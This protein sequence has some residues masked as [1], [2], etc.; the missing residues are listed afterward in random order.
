MQKEVILKC[1]F[2]LLIQIYKWKIV[3]ICS[4]SPRGNV[5][6]NTLISR[7][8]HETL[9]R[10]PRGNVDWNHQSQFVD[11]PFHGRSPRGNVDWNHQQNTC[12]WR[13]QSRS[14]RG[15]VDWNHHFP[16]RFRWIKL[17]FPTRER[18]LKWNCVAAL[19]FKFC[20][21]PRG[22]VDWNT[23]LNSGILNTSSRSP[24]GNVD[25]NAKTTGK[26]YW[27]MQSFPTRERGLK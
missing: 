10:S 16:P 5:D 25:W 22:N 27:G 14:P 15:N 4:R 13:Y 3:E 20:R 18:G 1:E 11:S 24:R 21:S 9:R 23:E 26:D 19:L 6:W 7:A 2:V 12:P 17:S 8:P